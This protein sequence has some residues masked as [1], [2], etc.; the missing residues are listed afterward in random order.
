MTTQYD[1]ANPPF[2]SSSSSLQSKSISGGNIDVKLKELRDYFMTDAISRASPT[3][4]KCISAVNKQQ[5]E[6]EAAKQCAAN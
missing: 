5:R 1:L 2:S 3:M 4:A 6:D